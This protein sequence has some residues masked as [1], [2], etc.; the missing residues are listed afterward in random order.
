MTLMAETAGTTGEAVAYL[1]HLDQLAAAT[2]CLTLAGLLV[3]FVGLVMVLRGSKPAE[4]PAII[5][6]YATCRPFAFRPGSRSCPLDPHQTERD[7]TPG[8]HRAEAD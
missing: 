3:W 2:T 4:R 7:A 1:P 6:A 5:R 8:R